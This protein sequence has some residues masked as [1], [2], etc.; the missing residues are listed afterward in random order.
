LPKRLKLSVPANNQFGCPTQFA[1]CGSFEESGDCEITIMAPNGMAT[2]SSRPG[3]SE[4]PTRYSNYQTSEAYLTVPT[5]SSL[6]TGLKEFYIDLRPVA[7]KQ[8]IS[9]GIW[10]LT[11]KNVGKTAVTLNVVSWVPEKPKDI[12]FV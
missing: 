10:Q 1:V 4:N 12:K 8:L 11:V 5:V 7:P 2:K 6:K 3:L 9:S